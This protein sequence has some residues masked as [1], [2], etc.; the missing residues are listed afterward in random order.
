MLQIAKPCELSLMTGGSLYLM[1]WA[2]A[3]LSG[4]G[5]KVFKVHFLYSE[6]GLVAFP[7]DLHGHYSIA[8]D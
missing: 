1:E 7:V 3:L 2:Y 4:I 5:L 8:R 6:P